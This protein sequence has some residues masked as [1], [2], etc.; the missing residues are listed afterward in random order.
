MLPLTSRSSVSAAQRCGAVS[1]YALCRSTCA[2]DDQVENER[3]DWQYY[4]IY[5]LLG[6]Q[7]FLAPL[8]TEKL[9]RVLDI[10]TGTGKWA[11][12]F[13]KWILRTST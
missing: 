7:H 11:I 5:I 3:L 4:T 10:G 8:R 9:K 13:G 12:E 1:S 6:Q 2:Y